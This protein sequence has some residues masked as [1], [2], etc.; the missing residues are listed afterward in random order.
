MK[1]LLYW[2]LRIFG[3]EETRVSPA[4]TGAFSSTKKEDLGAVTAQLEEYGIGR[5][6]AIK[7]HECE[8]S[9]ALMDPLRQVAEGLLQEWALF[10]ANAIRFSRQIP[11]SWE[12]LEF[13]GG[14]R[15]LFTNAASEADLAQLTEV[16]RTVA[17]TAQQAVRRREVEVASLNRQISVLHPVPAPSPPDEA[18]ESLE[19]R[20][21]RLR[22]VLHDKAVAL[23][24]RAASTVDDASSAQLESAGDESYRKWQTSSRRSVGF[25]LD[26][27]ESLQRAGRRR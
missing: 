4:A 17:E 25:F 19:D 24:D 18:S 27:V 9:P 10:Q 20:V 11:A 15:P 7:L 23:L 3:G 16:H 2:L 13:S 1:R 8:P 6:L 12:T 14:I 5:P 26:R 21:L 22:R